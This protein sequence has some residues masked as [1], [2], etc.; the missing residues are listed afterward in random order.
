MENN[1][2]NNESIEIFENS[3]FGK[4][5][6]SI[7]KDGKPLFCG[8]DVARV[9]GYKDATKAVS[10]HCKSG[11]RV[12]CPVAS[13]GGNY[14]TFIPEKDVYRLIMRSKLPSAE[15]FQD[16]V[17]DEVLPSLRKHG[18]YVVGM[19]ANSYQYDDEELRAIAWAKERK[20]LRLAIE[21]NKRLEA[22]NKRMQPKEQFYDLFMNCGYMTSI[23]D[24][25]I[26]L[27]VKEDTL[28]SFL[29]GS[30]LLYRSTNKSGTLRPYKTKTPTWFQLKDHNDTSKP[31]NK[32]MITPKGKAEIY[33]MLCNE[34]IIDPEDVRL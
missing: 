9:L 14:I 20:A 26:Q 12:F 31:G 6:T 22:D 27:Q 16:W 29:I 7:T 15:K 30:K 25:A 4:V 24:F 19:L 5:R 28:I 32:I 34:H 11:T 10:N 17:C 13:G 3:E 23:R 8:V 21:D 33:K 18:V 2:I 1:L